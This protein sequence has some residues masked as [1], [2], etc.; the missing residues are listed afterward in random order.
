[1][2]AAAGL[3]SVFACAVDVCLKKV[4]SEVPYHGEADLNPWA[5]VFSAQG[6][7]SAGQ[8]AERG[9]SCYSKRPIDEFLNRKRRFAPGGQRPPVFEWF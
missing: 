5:G 3:I 6:F 4:R 1:M 9:V 7:R 8:R 2:K